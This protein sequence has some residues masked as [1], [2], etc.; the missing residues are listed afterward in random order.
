MRRDGGDLMDFGE[1]HPHAPVA[2]AMWALYDSSLSRSKSGLLQGSD[3]S[4]YST[5]S[6]DGRVW[7]GKARYTPSYPFFSASFQGEYFTTC[8]LLIL[9]V[10]TLHAQL[11]V[12]ILKALDALQ[13]EIYPL[14]L[15]HSAVPK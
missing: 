12:E 6:G 7:R 1:R 9:V 5:V 13:A 4:H 2:A 3:R 11:D 10:Y 8:C 14:F 15:L